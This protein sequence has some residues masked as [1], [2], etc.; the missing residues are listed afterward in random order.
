MP[1]IIDQSTGKTSMAYRGETPWHGLGTPI[2]PNTTATQ[3]L[4]IA[5][6]DWEVDTVANHYLKTVTAIGP[7]GETLSRQKP[8]PGIGRQVIRLDTMASLGNVGDAYTPIPNRKWAQ[9]ADAVMPTG[10]QIETAFAL[11]SGESVG[12]LFARTEEIELAG[13][14]HRQYFLW[15][16]DHSGRRAARVFSTPVRVVCSNTLAMAFGA[17]RKSDKKG[18]TLRHTTGVINHL[19]DKGRLTEALATEH[20]IFD[21]AFT[22]MRERTVTNR[23]V[24]TYFKKVL[25]IKNPGFTSADIKTWPTRT[26]AR[27]MKLGNFYVQ[28]PTQQ[29]IKG[30]AY[31]LMQAV[32]GVHA[33]DSYGAESDTALARKEARALAYTDRTVN[34]RNTA[35]VKLA[36]ALANDRPTAVAV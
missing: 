14:K 27:I 4:T 35:A 9:T 6:L 18:L 10:F 12:F 34:A 21:Q 22:R 19:D 36:L 33:R 28:D 30:T 8:V 29:D 7:E 24:V 32:T 20:E 2:G 16:N 1:A 15:I 31:G 3:A 5:H 13:D 23:E 11:G 17:L 25:D 26:Q